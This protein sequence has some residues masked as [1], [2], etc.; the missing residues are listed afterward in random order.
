[1]KRFTPLLKE[2][3]EKLNLPQ[4]DKS[5]ILLEFGADMND[6][7][8]HYMA[9][10][11]SETEA[12]QLIME[13]FRVSDEALCELVKVHQG[14][15]QKL[16]NKFSRQAQSRWERT[17]LLLFLLFI[18]LF[19][20]RIIMSSQFFHIASSY[21]ALVIIFTV[22][23]S[24]LTLSKFYSLYI[25]KNHSIK[26]L[27]YGM[28]ELVFLGCGCLFIGLYGYFMELYSTFHVMSAQPDN[29]TLLLFAWLEKTTPLMVFTLSAT[30]VT[31][32]LWYVLQNKINKIQN[33]ELT[34]LLNM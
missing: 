5:R 23:I 19:C 1:M 24:V 13:K 27:N 14:L 3:N 6:L 12:M 32:L 15:F 7:F 29:S 20:G 8:N 2:L 16:A 4:P 34:F 11:K 9:Q 26:T 30:S 22:L 18:I 33:D 31:G 17:G 28:K 25:K 10:G 21:I